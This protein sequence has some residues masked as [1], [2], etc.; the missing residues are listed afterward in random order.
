MQY[1]PAFIPYTLLYTEISTNY[2]FVSKL[3]AAIHFVC[4]I[5]LYK[6]SLVLFLLQLRL[7][8]YTPPLPNNL[9]LNVR[10]I[11]LRKKKQ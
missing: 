1:A 3:D 9:N 4:V 6:Q 2:K 8:M 5:Y 11:F 7:K 10:L